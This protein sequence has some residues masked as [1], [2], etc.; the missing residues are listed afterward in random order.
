M[1]LTRALLLQ[2]LSKTNSN[3][4]AAALTVVTRVVGFAAAEDAAEQ[5]MK[6]LVTKVKGTE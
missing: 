6:H 1:L 2:A 5:R 4:V 3:E